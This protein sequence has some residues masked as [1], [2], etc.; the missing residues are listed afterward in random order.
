MQLGLIGLGKMGYP[1][2]LNGKDHGLDVVTYS[3]NP[4]KLE[5]IQADGL[6]GFGNLADFVDALESPRV[7]WL[8]IPA[9]DPVDVMI[10]RLIPLLKAGD[11]ILDGG[12]SQYQDS[13]RRHRQL[14]DMGLGFADVGTSGGTAGARHGA[15][16]MVGCDAAA[17]PALEPLFVALSSGAGCGH[18]GPAGAGHYVKMIHN[19]IEYGMMQAIGEGLQILR[20]SAFD[21][22][23]DQVAQVWREGSIISGL[24]MDVTAETLRKEPGLASIEGIVSASGEAEWT[25]QEA[26]RLRVSA[27]VIAASLFARFKSMDGER[28]SEKSLAAMR[29]EFGGHAVTRRGEE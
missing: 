3:E 28:F 21:F 14:S 1:L 5:R 27:P 6:Q 25:L 9:G 24:L 16:L 8:M 4:E 15:C 23:L 13:M 26:L 20:Q 10:Q 2:A 18:M 29:G 17:Y 12:N 19:G 22:Q 7:I 11:T